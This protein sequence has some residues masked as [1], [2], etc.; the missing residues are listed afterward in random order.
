MRKYKVGDVLWT[1]LLLGG[2]QQCK[3]V[4]LRSEGA[5]PVYGCSDTNEVDFPNAHKFRLP[6]AESDLYET[7]EGAVEARSKYKNAKTK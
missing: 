7:K 4:D 3:V 5:D 6:F 2:V 1:P